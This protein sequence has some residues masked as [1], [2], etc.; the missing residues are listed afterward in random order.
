MVSFGGKVGHM[1]IYRYYID[2]F[3]FSGLLHNYVSGLL[4]LF[5]YMCY[6]LTFPESNDGIVIVPMTIRFVSKFTEVEANPRTPH[7]VESSSVWVR[8]MF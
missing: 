4:F 5:G 7:L 1:L 6:L 8:S 2:L 3:I